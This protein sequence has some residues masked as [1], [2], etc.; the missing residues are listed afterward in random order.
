MSGIPDPAE[1]P[2]GIRRAL[3][4]S[5]RRTGGSAVGHGGHWMIS[6]PALAE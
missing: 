1:G 3:P 6:L 2:G 5:G 4:G